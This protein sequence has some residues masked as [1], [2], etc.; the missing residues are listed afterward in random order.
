MTPP[1]LLDL[2]CGAGGAA[3]G[4][5]RAGFRVIGIDSAP[6]P[7]YPFEFFQTDALEWLSSTVDNGT[8]FDAAHAS[9]PC[10]AYLALTDGTNKG[11]QYPRLIE[12]TRELL[13][14]IGLPYVIECPQRWPLVDPIRLCGEM[15]ALD[16]IR[17]RFFESNIG[18]IEPEHTAHRGRMRGWRHGQY[19]DGPYIAVYGDGGAKVH[20]TN[21]SARWVSTG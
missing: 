1:L 19:F 5:H 13:R 4:Y 3:M 15:Y 11:R 17:H 10:Q 8:M 16:V 18:L 9:P 6:Q 7:N 12:P 2:Y 21:A 14:Q 20:W